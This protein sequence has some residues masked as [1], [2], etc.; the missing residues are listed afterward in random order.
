MFSDAMAGSSPK[1]AVGSFIEGLLPLFLLA[2]G[3]PL[4][5]DFPVKPPD[6]ADPNRRDFPFST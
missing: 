5:N 6:S 2:S 1:L 3:D 4:I